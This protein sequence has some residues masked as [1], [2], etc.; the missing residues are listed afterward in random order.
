ME[1]AQRAEGRFHLATAGGRFDAG[2]VVIAAGLG[3][4]QPRR[5]GI[6]GAEA[7]EGAPIH[8]RVA[9]AAAFHGRHIVIFGGGDSALDWTLELRTKAASL[10]LVH[11][12]HEFRAA[13]A[14]VAR[15]R[16]LVVAGR[17]RCFEAL[18]HSLIVSDGALRG[19]NVAAPTAPS[20]RSQPNSCWCSSACIRNSGR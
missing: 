16:E 20:P 9:N 11:R 17:M 4:F 2:S 6:E 15:M 19:V 3:S 14:S 1:F 8:Y 7:F 10:T 18:P 12:R 13:P 5:I